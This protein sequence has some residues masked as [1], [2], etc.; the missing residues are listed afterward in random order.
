MMYLGVGSRVRARSNEAI[1]S[2]PHV[3]R[4]AATMMQQTGLPGQFHYIEP[5]PDDDDH[6]QIGYRVGCEDATY[7]PLN[8]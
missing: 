7:P 3:A 8:T 2:H 4:Y 5:E 6:E 1:V